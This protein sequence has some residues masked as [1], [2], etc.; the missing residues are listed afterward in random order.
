MQGNTTIV[1]VLIFVSLCSLIIFLPLLMQRP[2]L[3]SVI[4]TF[5]K[6]NAFDANSA[7]PGDAF[8]I[9]RQHFL[10]RKRDYK[11]Q[12]LQLLASTK[13]VQLTEDDRFFFSEEK[14]AALRMNSAKLAKWL[15]PE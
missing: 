9:S 7:I 5:R 13:I 10:L 1:T 8:G 14:Y 2:A 6:K 15:F 4:G 11:P 3:G 12:A